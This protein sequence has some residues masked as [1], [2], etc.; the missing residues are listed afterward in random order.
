VQGLFAF[1]GLAVGQDVLANCY[2]VI[3][4][5]VFLGEENGWAVVETGVG[6]IRY[7]LSEVMPVTHP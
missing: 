4:P 7:R 5:G 6:L 2:G 3:R 1:D